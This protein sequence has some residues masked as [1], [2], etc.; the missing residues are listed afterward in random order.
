MTTPI[1]VYLAGGEDTDFYQ[2][3]GQSIT[4][5]TS[6]FRTA[7]ARCGLGTS[8]AGTGY[9]QNWVP[10]SASTFWFGAR[11]WSNST[12]SN[13]GL[14][15]PIVQ[16][17]DASNIVRISLEISSSGF[18]L[19]KIDASSTKTLLTSG[20]LIW[21][22]SSFIDKFDM[23][24]IDAVSGSLTVYLNGIQI[25]TYSGDTTTNG[26]STLANIRLASASGFGGAF[27]WSEVIISDTDTRSMDLYTLVPAANGN[28]HN[29]DTGTPAAANINEIVLNDSTLDGSS[30]AGQIDEYTVQTTLP[31]GTYTILAIGVS[32][33]MQK[34]LSGPSKADFLVRSGGTDY[35][36]ADQVLTT[37]WA[38]YQNW[39]TTDPNTSGLWASLPLNIGVKSVT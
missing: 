31:A 24:V 23:R 30:V 9:W 19:Y 2:V 18:S 4:S 26:V 39:W 13:G 33:R 14:A 22:G 7:F 25:M 15:D 21:S 32:G 17:L 8:F 20:T 10:F 1:V 11:V 35:A 38:G 6:Q 12:G 3:G 37:T 5:N 36:S 27:T 34:G 29:F 16:F 28:T